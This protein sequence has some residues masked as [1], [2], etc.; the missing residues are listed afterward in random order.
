M[1]PMSTATRWCCSAQVPGTVVS[2]LTD[3]TQLVHAGEV[4]VKLDPNDAE[5]DLARAESAL[6][7][8]VRQVRQQRATHVNTMH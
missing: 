2:V 5:I 3:D 8:T 6:G 7:E 4:L 1:T